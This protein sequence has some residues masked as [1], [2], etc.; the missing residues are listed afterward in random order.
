[1][2]PDVCLLRRCD[3]V[4]VIGAAALLAASG[5]GYRRIAEELDR[6]AETV[7]DW[8]SRFRSRGELVAVHFWRWARA[9]DGALVLGVADGATVVLGALEA[10]GVCTRAASLCVAASPRYNQP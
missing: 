10:I 3:A 4:E 6:P 2:L 9:L 1:L 7:R 5:A 8:L